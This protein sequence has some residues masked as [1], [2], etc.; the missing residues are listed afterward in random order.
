[1]SLS[2]QQH[3][4]EQRTPMSDA[5]E[6]LEPV[7]AALAGE[8]MKV[9]AEAKSALDS[10]K[11]TKASTRSNTKLS[12]SMKSL[13]D[14][15]SERHH[16]ASEAKGVSSRNSGTS[17]GLFEGVVVKE[18]TLSLLVQALAVEGLGM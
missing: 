1:M 14:D 10:G 4:H 5:H 9:A 6:M 7:L 13:E 12:V 15:G 18:L 2:A 17:A 11:T 8:A 16:A 3:H